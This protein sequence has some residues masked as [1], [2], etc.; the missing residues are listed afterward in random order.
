MRRPEP[1]IGWW[2]GVT[3]LRVSPQRL[4]WMLL[5]AGIAT[6]LLSSGCGD[7]HT[8]TDRPP[9]DVVVTTLD[10]RD[11]ATT[12]ALLQLQRTIGLGISASRR[13]PLPPSSLA[14]VAQIEERWQSR[15]RDLR[16]FVQLKNV[17]DPAELPA[18]HH[19][20]LAELAQAPGAWPD[21]V[22]RFHATTQHELLRLLRTAGDDATD[23]DLRA[24]AVRNRPATVSTV[25]LLAHSGDGN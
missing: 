24:L 19:A 2:H 13:Q 18:E 16:A 14:L 8:R 3:S 23:E 4:S 21:A 9:P 22:R 15:E 5:A 12:I 7:V 20:W 10:E 1:S 17:P 6:C 25:D 11:L